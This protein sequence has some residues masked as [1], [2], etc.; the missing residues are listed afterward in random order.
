MLWSGKT[1]GEISLWYSQLFVLYCNFGKT[2]WCISV[3]MPKYIKLSCKKCNVKWRI[4]CIIGKEAHLSLADDG[5]KWRTHEQNH[6]CQHVRYLFR[7]QAWRFNMPQQSDK[8]SKW[9]FQVLQQSKQDCMW[10]M[11]CCSS[12]NNTATDHLRCHSSLRK[13]AS[14]EDW[15]TGSSPRK[16]RRLREWQQF[17]QV[18]KIEGL[19][20]VQASE[21]DWRS[22]SSPSRG[23]KKSMKLT[24]W[25]CW[26]KPDAASS[27]S[28]PS[29]S[30]LSARMACSAAEPEP[31]AN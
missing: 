9:R 22:G 10:R 17:K 28:K 26:P 13:T 8:D 11:R 3:C 19:A 27:T 31:T 1:S 16:W 30:A 24:C 4:D 25:C 2:P 20:A 7:Q 29:L 21:E 23:L 5:N 14:E 15:R 18:K 12:Q 6:D